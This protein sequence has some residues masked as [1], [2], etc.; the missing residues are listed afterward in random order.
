M[1]KRIPM[2]DSFVNES[3]TTFNLKDPEKLNWEASFKKVASSF[4]IV[5]P[6]TVAHV[7]G[8]FTEESYDLQIYMSDGKIFHLDTFLEIGPPAP[9][10]GK[11]DYAKISEVRPDLSIVRSINLDTSTYSDHLESWGDK[12]PLVLIA[13]LFYE[14]KKYKSLLK[15]VK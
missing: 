2:F 3:V 15:L 5:D 7:A 12:F 8:E 13:A 14:D 6:I 1:K 11:R 9:Y 4:E 10:G